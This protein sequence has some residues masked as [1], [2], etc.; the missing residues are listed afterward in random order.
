MANRTKDA[1]GARRHV[2]DVFAFL[3]VATCGPALR[4]EQAA[5][6]AKTKVSKDVA[7]PPK[8]A[9]VKLGLA[10]N[11]PKAPSRVTRC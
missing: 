4:A 7:G 3:L 11:E 8:K 2:G 10:I 9:A 1:S 5:D 6:E